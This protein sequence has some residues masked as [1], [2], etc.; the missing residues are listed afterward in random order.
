MNLMVN[1]LP[2]ITWNRLG[3]NRAM[4]SLEGEYR[5]HTPEADFDETQIF[6]N[7]SA[8]VSLEGLH[9]DLEPIVVNAA[10]GFGETAP[11]IQME[12]PLALAYAYAE[13]EKAV[14]HLSL[15][16]G[17]ESRLQALL[18][19]TGDAE[20]SAIQTE[21]L[22]DDN[23]VVD[24]YV[25]QLLGSRS[26]SLFNIAAS[27]GQNAKI[28][29]VKLEL[30]AGKTYAGAA[31]DLKGTESSFD[32]RIGYHVKPGQLLDMN[33]VALHHGRRTE[34]NMEVNGTLEEGARKT[35]RGTIDFQQ[36][37]AGAKGTENENVMLMGDE[38]VNQTIPLI[39]CKE[40]D[41]EGNH[42]ASIGQLD[43]KVLF[44]LAS[45]GMSREA[46]QAMIAQA[47]I[48]AICELFPLEQVRTQVRDFENAR[49]ISH[50]EEC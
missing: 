16:A 24:I 43:E 29:L 23:A 13:G 22:A 20:T 25:A 37:C 32:T 44:Y 42:G 4:V 12:F 33:Y 28:N 39:L 48:D 47:R 15:H 27:C 19:L 18:I 30:G 38:M 41:V 5:N 34:S 6:W 14:S 36:G 46:A 2:S 3:M 7:P 9:G 40:E 8:E 10:I 21:I 50:G 17:E 26:L 49:G 31:V 35:F 11:G 45:R 1:E